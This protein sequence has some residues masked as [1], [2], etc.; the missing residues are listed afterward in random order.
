MSFV[1]SRI[2]LFF[3]RVANV[4][5]PRVCCTGFVFVMV[6]V[7]F[8]FVMSLTSLVVFCFCGLNL[9]FVHGDGKRWLQGVE[10]CTCVCFKCVFYCVGTI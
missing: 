1:V 8:G 4:V 6:G 9:L 5:L 3:V 7:A 10:W 2:R